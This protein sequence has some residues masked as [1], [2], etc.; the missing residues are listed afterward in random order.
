MKAGLASRSKI[1]ERHARP[2]VCLGGGGMTAPSAPTRTVH[3]YG[4]SC[5]LQEPQESVCDVPVDDETWP[6]M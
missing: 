4:A 3:A 1:N 6:E 2:G 5:T